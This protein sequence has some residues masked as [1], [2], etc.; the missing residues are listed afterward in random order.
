M[1]SIE[2][3]ANAKR[4]IPCVKSESGVR[5]IEAPDCA[6]RAERRV[7]AQIRRE[8]GHEHCAERRGAAVEADAWRERAGAG[9]RT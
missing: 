3:Q 2:Q 8:R 9:W 4:E 5:R 1:I 6:A 7:E